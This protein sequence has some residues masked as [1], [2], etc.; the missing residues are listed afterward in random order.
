MWDVDW[1][2]PEIPSLDLVHL[3]MR[4]TQALCR[5]GCGMSWFI[6][7]QA[8]S[9]ALNEAGNV[10]PACSLLSVRFH[11]LLL[12]QWLKHWSGLRSFFEKES[13][14]FAISAIHG[15]ESKH[16]LQRHTC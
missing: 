2:M 13:S 6:S 8:S 14:T 15:Q 3:L 9:S 11:F 4:V 7:R 16:K 5:V 1:E 12:L 10:N